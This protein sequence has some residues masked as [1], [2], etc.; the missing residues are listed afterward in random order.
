MN[1]KPTPMTN[2]AK[3]P[4]GMQTFSEIIR[5]GYAYVD[6]TDLVYKI[7]QDGTYYVLTRPRRFGKSLL[8]STLEAYFSGEKDL[9]GGLAISTLEDK[10]EE[11]PILHLDFNA[12]KYDSVEALEDKL[13]LALSLWED[14]CGSNPAERSLSTRFEG[15]LRR[16]CEQTGRQVVILVDEYDKPLLQAIGS[17]SLQDEYRIILKAFYGTLKSC[18]RYIRF[19]FLTGVTK[20]GKVS[21]FS[22]LNNLQ[23]ISF[24]R[25]YTRLCGITEDELHRDF[26]DAVGLLARE[27]GLSK[28]AC[29]AR[30][31][32][33]FDGY[34]FEWGTEG[35]YNPF[36]LLCTLSSRQFR[37]YWFQTG[38]PS[39]LVR[40]L[41]KTRYRLDDM[42]RESISAYTLGSIDI[43]DENPLPLLYQSGYLTIKGYDAEF[44][45][46]LLGFPN[47]EVREGFIKYL[48]PFYTP[49]PQDRT[50]F[51][52]DK[53]V[54]EIRG[55]KAEDFMRRMEAFFAQGDYALMGDKELYFQNAMYV[56]FML[57]GLYV[58]VER[59]TTDGRMDMLVKTG[60]YIYIFEL[61][62]DGSAAAA[63]R[64]I[65]DKGYAR[66]F[67]RDPRRLFKI[68]VNFS[69]QKGCIDGWEVV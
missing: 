6:K 65:E 4:I 46:Y 15:V 68:G 41:Q 64:Q 38:T 45:S 67:A 47:R 55:G 50:M 28:E 1:P 14:S 16:T 10:W 5:R 60:E 58:E 2:E 20:F 18:D 52:I 24:D 19:A 39:L 59:H 25:R 37:Y 35:M 26:D 11:Y 42:T 57:L 49:R 12:E 13:N 40:Q 9:F 32:R 62:M 51:S 31:K 7:V 23:D 8:L 69:S 43:M 54:K 44:G 66:P 53:F 27:N 56:F 33:D 63:L 48:L 34:H 61:K 36:S 29:Y 22:D 21:V 3:Y 30:L 17:E